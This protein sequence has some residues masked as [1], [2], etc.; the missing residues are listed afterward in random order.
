MLDWDAPEEVRKLDR[1]YL[2]KYLALAQ[3]HWHACRSQ[4]ARSLIIDLKFNLKME[5][6]RERD[7]R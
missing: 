7:D 4:Y 3:N 1:L 5:K 6:Q 2:E